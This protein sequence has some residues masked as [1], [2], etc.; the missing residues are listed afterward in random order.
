MPTSIPA[1][2]EKKAQER[3]TYV[4][5]GHDGTTAST[6]AYGNLMQISRYFGQ[7]AGNP[8]GF[9][10]AQTTDED[11]NPPFHALHRFS[12]LSSASAKKG[13]GFRLWM[14]K[15]DETTSMPK[16]TFVNNRWPRFKHEARLCDFEVQY[17]VREGTVYQMYTFKVDKDT[18]YTSPPEVVVSS[19]LRIQDLDYTKE[20][21]GFDSLPSE[22]DLSHNDAGNGTS[23]GTPDNHST[24][25]TDSDEGS[26][27]S[28]DTTSDDDYGSSSEN[29]QTTIQL[30]KPPRR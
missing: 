22:G 15:N 13:L 28:F 30:S 17:V 18:K 2:A 20:D 14:E 4:S 24:S 12:D 11:I 5:F 19:R 3:K 16:M 23:D 8:S 25:D 26:I 27:S 1:S 6:N 9:F 10:C 29:E 21:D 7:D